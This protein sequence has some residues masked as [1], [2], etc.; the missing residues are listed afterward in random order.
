MTQ[1]KAEPI[2]A[3]IPIRSGLDEQEAII[4][5]KVEAQPPIL[6]RPQPTAQEPVVVTGARPLPIVSIEPVRTL[7]K[8]PVNYG[9]NVI[10]EPV[11]VA[12]A[13]TKNRPT[14]KATILPP[15]DVVTATPIPNKA[16]AQAELSTMGIVSTTDPIIQPP[17]TVAPAIDPVSSYPS[18]VPLSLIHISE[19]TRPY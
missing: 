4:V 8:E 5:E 3:D 11:P 19:P 12:P 9:G 7:D 2:A 16:A 10:L 13:A 1:P 17:S 14:Q 15:P 6:E 18:S